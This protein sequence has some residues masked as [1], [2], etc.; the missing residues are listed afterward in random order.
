MLAHTGALGC[1]RLDD[2]GR[3]G[4]SPKAPPLSLSSG[5]IRPQAIPY[6]P[7]GGTFTWYEGGS[8]AR[9]RVFPSVGKPRVLG[10]YGPELVP[11]M[12][13]HSRVKDVCR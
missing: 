8:V 10:E 7:E 9:V 2:D 5:H 4:R 6:E 1:L 3:A 13:P 12:A 11:G